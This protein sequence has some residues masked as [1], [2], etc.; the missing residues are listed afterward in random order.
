MRRVKEYVFEY[1]LIATVMV[2][3]VLGFWGI[4]FG[5]EA[6][7]Q[8]HHH[9]HVATAFLWMFLLLFQLTLIGRGSYKTHRKVGLTV[10]VAGPLLVAT[11]AM[12]SVHSAT[13]RAVAQP[14]RT[15]STR[16]A[17]WYL[18]NDRLPGSMVVGG[19]TV[20]PYF[21]DSLRRT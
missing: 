5:A 10:L 4:Y 19:T 15:R 6:D 1:L 2:I 11:T 8:P 16:P 17:A 7:P 9:L 3:S 12:L 13:L 20:L 21:F 18:S 14:P